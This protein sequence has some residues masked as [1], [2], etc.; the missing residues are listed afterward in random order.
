MV[1]IS[2]IEAI[3]DTSGLVSNIVEISIVD[4]DQMIEILDRKQI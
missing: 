1:L 2:T 3:A 4:K